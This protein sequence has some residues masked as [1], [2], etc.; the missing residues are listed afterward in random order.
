MPQN[1]TLKTSKKLKVLA[2]TYE[3]PGLSG[4][5]LRAKQI[6][7][8][9]IENNCDV[10]LI[11]AS[12]EPKLFPKIYFLT[13]SHD[14]TLKIIESPGLLKKRF[15][16][17]GTDPYDFF[18]RCILNLLLPTDIFHAFNPKLTTVFPALIASKLKNKPVFFDWADLWGKGG[19]HELKKKYFLSRQSSRIETWIENWIPTRATAVTTISTA[20]YN[21]CLKKNATPFFLPVGLAQDITIIPPIKA[22]LKLNFP[23]KNT[24]VGFTFTDSPDSDFLCKIV[25]ATA[26]IDPSIQFVLMGPPIERIQHAPN[27]LFN[28]FVARN[29][30]STYLAACDF[31]ILPFKNKKIN[32][33]RYPNKIGDFLAANKPFISNKTGDIKTLIETQEIGWLTEESAQSFAEKIVE[34]SKNK[35][36]LAE[37]IANIKKNKKNL[38]WKALT[39]NLKRMYLTQ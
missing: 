15:R 36:E 12:S 6:C 32:R 14:S 23:Q 37:K 38:T 34:I 27:V 28:A 33:Y 39:K 22:R 1:H 17:G 8:G 19:I 20:M 10:S 5:Y 4:N 29:E 11:T 26:K 2:S 16:H 24:L 13:N 35:I 21:Q 3:M 7:L 31:C 25:E 9:L 30:M 18:W